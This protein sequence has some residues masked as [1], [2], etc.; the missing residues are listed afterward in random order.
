MDV[1]SGTCNEINA[2]YHQNLHSVN[3]S[4][5]I[6]VCYFYSH[7]LCKEPLMYNLASGEY[8]S[9]NKNNDSIMSVRCYIKQTNELMA[10]N[11]RVDTKKGNRFDIKTNQDSEYVVLSFA[12]RYS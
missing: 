2:S 4:S 1:H 10:E 11:V 6:I 7:S 8:K 5:E 12:S 9:L 3:I